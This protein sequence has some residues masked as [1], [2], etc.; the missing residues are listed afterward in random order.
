MVTLDRTSRMRMAGDG[1]VKKATKKKEGL[2][3]AR[4][5]SSL[6]EIES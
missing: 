2:P 3:S 4:D 1:A 6:G 5:S